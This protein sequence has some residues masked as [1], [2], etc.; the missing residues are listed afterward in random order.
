MPCDVLPVNFLSECEMGW[1]PAHGAEERARAP[2]EGL[3]QSAPFLCSWESCVWPH[4][5]K[6][7]VGFVT[8]V[9]RLLSQDY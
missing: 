9:F 1:Q 6:G 4:R 3:E 2:K 8:F 7:D 5:H